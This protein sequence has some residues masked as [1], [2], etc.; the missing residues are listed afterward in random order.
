[1]FGTEAKPRI[2]P[3][4]LVR[5]NLF[6]TDRL[7]RDAVAR[8]G[9]A[10]AVPQLESFGRMLGTAEAIEWGALSTKTRPFYIPTTAMDA[11]ATKWSFTP[12]GTT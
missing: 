9:A 8:E 7:L 2:H 6:S 3:P 11:A 5:Y 1:M 10:W 12:P 4:P